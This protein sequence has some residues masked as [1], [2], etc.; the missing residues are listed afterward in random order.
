M[1]DEFKKVTNF[2]LSGFSGKENENIYVAPEQVSV[3][4]CDTGIS[5]VMP[6]GDFYKGTKYIK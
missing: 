2:S 6:S 5:F 1:D 3:K 4:N